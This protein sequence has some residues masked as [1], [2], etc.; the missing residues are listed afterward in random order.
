[1]DYT[2]F[3]HLISPDGRPHGQVDR[4][5]AGGAAPTTSWAPGQVIVDEIGLPVAADAPAGTY[6]IAVGMYDG[7]SGGRLP[8]TDGSG[9]PLP[10]DQAVLPVEITVGP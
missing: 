9:Q 3:V 6:H 4:F 10:D 2:V 8:V 5:P 7:A 1:L